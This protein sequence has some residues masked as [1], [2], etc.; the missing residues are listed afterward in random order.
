MSWLRNLTFILAFSLC[1][2][3]S[4]ATNIDSG[5]NGD[6]HCVQ[7]SALLNSNT[8]TNAYS[9]T[10]AST[11]TAGHHYIIVVEYVPLITGT[12][13]SI[14]DNTGGSNTYAVDKNFAGTDSVTFA[15]GSGKIASAVTNAKTVNVNFSANMF[16]IA[17]M[18]C[19]R[20]DLAASNWFDQ[21]GSNEALGTPTSVTVMA[22]AP[23]SQ[24][25]MVVVGVG[26]VNAT[27]NMA[28]GY[29]ENW[30][31]N[32]YLG[33]GSAVKKEVSVVTSQ[34]TYTLTYTDDAGIIATYKSSTSVGGGCNNS[35]LLLGAG[36]C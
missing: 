2:R 28:S 17:A 33:G 20:D 12:L 13:S 16:A 4:F 32:T 24:A 11:P 27:G 23:N 19:E 36:G 21:S 26:R 9:M 31:E 1:A 7:C 18:V 14:T 3:A 6:P 29:T 10:L 25:S 5:C 22:S 15:I 34:I 8:Q 30:V 35:L